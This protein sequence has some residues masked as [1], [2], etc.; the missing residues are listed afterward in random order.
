MDKKKVN[1]PET[2]AHPDLMTLF[3][4]CR[5]ESKS[6]FSKRSTAGHSLLKVLCQTVIRIDPSV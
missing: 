3:S 1:H 2:Q 5:V 4:S 6:W